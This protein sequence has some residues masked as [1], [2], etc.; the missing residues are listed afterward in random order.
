MS[1][2]VIIQ[3]TRPMLK[4][5]KRKYRAAVKNNEHLFLFD[6]HEIMTAYGRYLI[7]YLDQQF[8]KDKNEHDG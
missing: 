7:E 5:F 4:R 2:Q 1:Q 8:G 3:W 6:G